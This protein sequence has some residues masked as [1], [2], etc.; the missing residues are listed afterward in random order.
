[1]HQSYIRPG[2]AAA[3]VPA[4][5]ATAGEYCSDEILVERIAAG[6]KLAVQVLFARMIFPPR[7]GWATLPRITPSIRSSRILTSIARGVQGPSIRK[8]S[9][10]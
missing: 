4:I 1:M 7:I 8:L 10:A 2:S 6:D 5:A 3:E 9:D